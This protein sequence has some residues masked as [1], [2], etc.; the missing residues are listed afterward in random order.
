MAPLPAYTIYMPYI[1]HL[2][3]SLITHYSYLYNT[4]LHEI[5][6]EII[7]MKPVKE[8][9]ENGRRKGREAE[10]EGLGEKALLDNGL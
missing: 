10:G 6:S 9:R 8:G 7:W 3:H 2:L 5:L 4:Y 1:I